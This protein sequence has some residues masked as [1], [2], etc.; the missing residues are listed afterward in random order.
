MNKLTNKS[1]ADGEIQS[2]HGRPTYDTNNTNLYL[3]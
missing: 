2:N 3:M 1:P